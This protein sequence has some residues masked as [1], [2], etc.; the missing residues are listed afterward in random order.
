MHILIECKDGKFR[1]R[2]KSDIRD[3]YSDSDG[4]TVICF[5]GAKNTPIRVS[6]TVEDFFNI[7]LTK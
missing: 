4:E 2:K 7:N 5:T 3:V 6:G 1:V